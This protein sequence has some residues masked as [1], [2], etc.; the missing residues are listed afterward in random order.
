MFD[1]LSQDIERLRE[2]RA[3]PFPIFLI[4]ALLF[5]NG[6]QAVFLYRLAH[7]FK[8][9]RIPFFGPFFG[10]LGQ[11]LTGVEIAPGATI[12][13][14]LM[15]SHGHGLVIGQWSRLGA[16]TTLMH[17]VTLG[18]PGIGRLD[19][20]P[21]LGDRVFV[22]AGAKLIGKIT[23]GDDVFIGANAVV[24]QDIPAGH[25]VLVASELK[26]QKKSRDPPSPTQQT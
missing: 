2:T 12:G 5:D 16:Q 15:I 4:E 14:G 20:M 18:A 8:A 21:T 11:F 17:Q 13:P 6:F 1:H 22:G 23:I 19:E 7:F 10:R 24:G 25:R 3:R 26:I 9:H